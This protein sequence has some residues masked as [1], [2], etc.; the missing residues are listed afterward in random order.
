MVGFP[1]GGVAAVYTRQKNS[2]AC[3]G[4]QMAF[5]SLRLGTASFFTSPDPSIYMEGGFVCGHNAATV[6]G[7][8]AAAFS[9]II[10]E[11]RELEKQTPTRPAGW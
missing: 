2:A 6:C 8:N 9:G 3:A 4:T 1:D 7:H 10:R 5:P 11:T